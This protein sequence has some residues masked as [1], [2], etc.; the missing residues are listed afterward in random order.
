MSTNDGA[1]NEQ[2]FKVRVS[3]AKLV[4]LLEDAGMGPASKALIDRIPVAVLV[5]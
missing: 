3:G 5:P 1:V 2:V 4:Q